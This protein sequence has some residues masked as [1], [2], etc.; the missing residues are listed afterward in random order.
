MANAVHLPTIP[1]LNSINMMS[2]GR[3][4]EENTEATIAWCRGFGFLAA[5][6]V[7]PMCNVDCY[8]AVYGRDIEGKIWR[9]RRCKKTINIR[10]GS[11]FEKSKL[12]L[13]QII[14]LTY[15]W[16]TNCGRGRRPSVET[17]MK[18]LKISSNKSVVDWNQFCRDVCVEYFANNPEKV[19][20]VGQIVEID[21]TLFARRKYNGGPGRDVPPQWIFGGYDPATTK[22]DFWY[23]LLHVMLNLVAYHST[24]G[25]TRYNGLFR[26]MESV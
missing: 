17:I 20:G 6:C 3:R 5:S 16:S 11:F 14:D 4:F 19:G 18:E 26:P 12:R 23:L 24:M 1:E 10:K 13:W 22:K 9:C 7:C 8:E 25:S 2:I 21:E 15:M